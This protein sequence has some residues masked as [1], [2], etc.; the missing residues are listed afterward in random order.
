MIT[1]IRKNPANR[2]S[3]MLV[4]AFIH[5]S[6]TMMRGFWYGIM[7]LILIGCNTQIAV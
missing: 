2:M 5:E 4:D 7:V 3:V 1:E 6:S